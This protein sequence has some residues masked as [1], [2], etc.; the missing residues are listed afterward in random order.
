MKFKWPK[1]RIQTPSGTED[2]IAPWI[3]SASRATDIPAFYGDWFFDK[4]QR[5]YVR[6][7]NPYNRHHQFVSFENTRV[8]VFWSKNPASIIPHLKQLDDLGL[9]CYFQFTLND[10]EDQR[11][12]PNLP[13]LERR[14]ETFMHL[15]EILGRNRVI[16]R[17]DP[18]LLTAELGPEGLIEKIHRIGERIYPFTEKL[19]FSF[20]DISN[21]KSVGKNMKRDGICYRDFESDTMVYMAGKIS[22]LNRPWGLNLAACAEKADFGKFGIARNR[23]IDEE[24]ILKITEK[25]LRT[26]EFDSFLGYERQKDLFHSD[27]LVKKKRLKDRGQR[28]DCDC[29][30]SKDIGSYNTCPHGCVYCYANTS[31]SAAV[32]NKRLIKKEDD[33]LLMGRDG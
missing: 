30:Y 8:I 27:G 22:V 33:A 11:F 28:K 16:W 24:L 23:C 7:I 9:T 26:P 1:T 20:A 10:Y 3:I 15:S 2:A 17:F 19:V 29:I 18:L 14:M 21:Y 4:L 31:K 12:E 13:A 25:S 32:K 6:W 5:G